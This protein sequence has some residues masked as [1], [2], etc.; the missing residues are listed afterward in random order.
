[1]SDYVIDTCSRV[2]SPRCRGTY[3]INRRAR[4]RNRKRNAGDLVCLYCS[5]F[6]KRGAR[7]PNAKYDYDR[8][9]FSDVDTEEKAYFL[10]WVASDGSIEEGQVTI[11][12]EDKDVRV[13]EGL[14]DSFCPKIPIK[15]KNNHQVSLRIC[16]QEITSD[17]CRWLGVVPGKKSTSVQFPPLV[18][19]ALG[20]A[21]V[22]GLF[23]GG[24][25]VNSVYG[26]KRSPRCSI[27]SSSPLMRTALF[28]FCDIPGSVGKNQVEWSGNNAL[29]FLARIYDGAELYLSRKRTRYLEWNNYVPCLFGS[30]HAGTLGVLRW[31]RINPEAV[32]PSKSRASDSG[33]DLT[34]L[35]KVKQIGEVALYSTGL[36]IT[37]EYGWYFDLV[38]RSSIIKSGYMLANG[39]GVIDRSYIGPIMVPLVK[40]D[41]SAPDLELP[42]RLVQIIPRPI[43]DFDIVEV[44][45]LEQTSRGAGGFGSTGV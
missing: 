9:F 12:I 26:K 37:P 11:T 4:D 43:V 32:P 30:K 7:N 39:F 22:R 2:V 33:Y 17:I 10:G 31:N 41:K 40:V 28:D 19:E 8:S 34:I 1:V 25:T 35:E 3:R 23:D 27:S 14:R 21:F 42:C 15:R 6:Q 38:G 44:A 13:L 20:W 5:R 36:R 45:E 18:D 29:D 16:S 24:G